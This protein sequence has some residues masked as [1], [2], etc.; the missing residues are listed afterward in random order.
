QQ[1][2]DLARQSLKDNQARVEVG[3]AAKIDTISSEAEV[4]SNEEAVIIQQAAIESAEDQLRALLMN[5]SQA[6]FWTMNFVPSDEASM[7]QRT[8]DVD[9]AVKNALEHR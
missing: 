9:A 3:T 6:G 2:L 8:I 1:S 4:A 7:T 5:P